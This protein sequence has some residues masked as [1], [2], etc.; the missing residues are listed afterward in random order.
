MGITLKPGTRLRSQVDGTEVIVVRPGSGDL[1]VA[2]GGHPM[3]DV[4]ARP[5]PGVTPVG[6]PGDGTQ[7]GKRYVA[8]EDS[9]VELLVTKP[10]SW[11]L[12]VDGQPAVLK[13]A[14]PLPA[15]D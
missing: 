11:P 1:E 5:A 2:C 7:L 12:T 9:G 10:G 3:I 15:S 13:E 4:Q 6:E 8:A 14:K